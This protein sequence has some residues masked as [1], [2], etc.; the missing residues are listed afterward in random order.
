MTKRKPSPPLTPSQRRD[1][2]F[3]ERE[4]A[5]PARQRELLERA[6]AEAAVK[7]AHLFDT[8]GHLVPRQARTLSDED[9]DREIDELI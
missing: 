2:E 9:R 8:E 3:A 1:Q 4:A 6:R 7:F 5:L